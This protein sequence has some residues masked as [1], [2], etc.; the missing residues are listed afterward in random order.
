MQAFK[1]KS[2]LVMSITNQVMYHPVIR[3][4]KHGQELKDNKSKL[5]GEE[6]TRLQRKLQFSNRSWHVK[7]VQNEVYIMM[8]LLTR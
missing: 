8:I 4:S 7:D 6:T 2:T 1:R 5:R 3:D